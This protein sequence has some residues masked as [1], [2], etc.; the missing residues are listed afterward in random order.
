M[1][2]YLEKEEK[3]K[4]INH[5][6]GYEINS[7]NI[8]AERVY[9]YQNL[10][11][12]LYSTKVFFQGPL[13]EIIDEYRN[14]WHIFD[15][16]EKLIIGN[17]EVGTGDYF[18]PIV[19]T[20]CYVGSAMLEKLR[21]LNIRD[22]KTLNEQAIYTLANQIMKIVIFESIVINNR[23]YNQ[24]IDEGYNA[25]VIKAWGHNQVLVKMIQHK[26]NYK[27]IVIDQFV[28]QKL[29]YQYLENMAAN[30]N[31]IVRDKVFFTTKAENKFLAVACS[32]IIS[33]YL[34]L[35]EIKK[36]ST[37]LKVKIP[38]GAGAEVDKFFLQHQD[39]F[40]KDIKKF[41]YRYTKY[42]FAN[43]KKILKEG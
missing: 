33:R 30:K 38:L 29:Y 17:D 27:K 1:V 24:W 43:T 14:Y 5:Y 21:L 42:H 41:L 40:N 10:T 11:I 25:N 6:H 15:E 32:A 8:H 4:I 36:L 2:F 18:G 37:E 7:N 9:K 22:S 39:F 3:A 34:F 26:N 12:T 28:D 23:K 20:S 35:E 13:E 19:I 31:R 16:K